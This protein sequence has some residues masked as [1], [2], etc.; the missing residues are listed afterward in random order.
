[1]IGLRRLVKT[2]GKEYSIYQLPCSDTIEVNHPFGYN[3]LVHDGK[4]LDHFK[5]FPEAELFLI[6]QVKKDFNKD[7]VR[8][9][10]TK[11]KVFDGEIYDK[12]GQLSS[13]K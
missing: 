13:I 12:T 4:V 1:M 11:H 6:S 8:I 3:Y 9:D 7:V 10:L 5:T 2:D